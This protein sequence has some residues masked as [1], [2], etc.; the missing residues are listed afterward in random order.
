MAA[1]I[2]VIAAEL[3]AAVEKLKLSEQHSLRMAENLD[4]LRL[5]TD[6]ALREANSKIAE[7]Q[8]KHFAGGRDERVDLID[9]KSMDPGSFSGLEKESWRQ[10][11]KRVKAYCN[12]RTPGFRKALDW[13]EAETEVIDS[14]SLTGLA[15]KHAEVANGK[16]FDM[17]ILKLADDPHH[18]GG[19]PHRTGVRSMEVVI[20]E[21]RPHR[22]TIRF[23]TDDV[24]VAQRPLQRHF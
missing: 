24:S 4:K 16:L 14:D 6:G 17:L 9:I 15:W 5:E 20:Q 19:E 22:R 18:P 23:R 2:D 8:Q 10:W 7:L 13:A 1:N 12:A 3:H 21:V 11:A